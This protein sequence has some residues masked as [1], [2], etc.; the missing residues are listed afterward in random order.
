MGEMPMPGGW[1]MSMAWMRMP[2]QTWPGAAASFLGMWIVMMVAMM[3]PSL[4]PMLWR[5]C[6]AVGSTGETRL[7]RLTA[8]VGVGYFVIWAVAGTAA[9]A[10]GAGVVALEMRWEKVAQWLP[11]AAG[12]V[13]LVAAGVQ[14]TSWKARQLA[15]CREGSGCDC[16][17]ALNALGAW[18]HGLRLGVRC[19][20]CCGNLILALLAI[21][22]L[23]LV[24]M[25][26]VTL[27]ISA[28]RLAPA[29]LRVERL[30]GVAMVVV[31]VLMIARV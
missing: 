10:A 11:A 19:S 16:P 8:L 20:L 3:L 13:L 23:D 7:G 31:G 27:A 26:A 4:V 21:G 12:G 24:A 5:Y 14:F 28:E 29:P 1:T 2:G 22:M 9:Y 30:A 25:A 17:P 18:R 6:R 15:L